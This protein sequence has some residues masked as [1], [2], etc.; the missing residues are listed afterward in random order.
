MAKVFQEDHY[1]YSFLGR[2]YG[3]PFK[4]QIIMDPD[5]MEYSSPDF[6]F[7]NFLCFDNVKES[8]PGDFSSGWR[9]L[10]DYSSPFPRYERLKNYI[11]CVNEEKFRDDAKKF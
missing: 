9:L 8:K 2:D 6:G 5:K 7:D 1:L 11:N 3:D 10:Q 4:G